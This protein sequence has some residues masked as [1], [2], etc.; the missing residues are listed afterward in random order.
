VG[1]IDSDWLRLAAEL[2]ASPLTA[3]SQRDHVHTA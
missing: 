2:I 3:K 1:Q